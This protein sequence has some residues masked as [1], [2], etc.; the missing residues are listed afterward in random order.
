M[1]KQIT[2]IADLDQDVDDVIA[3][4]YLFNHHVLKEIITDPVPI[5]QI[6][7]ERRAHLESLGISVKTTLTGKHDYVFV[8]GAL[9]TV[10]SYI[11]LSYIDTL[12]MNGGFVGCNLIPKEHQLPKFKDKKTVRTF[13]FNCNVYAT[14]Q[15][16][17]SSE[18][19]IEN[20]ILVGKNVCHSYKNTDHDLWQAKEYTDLFK[21]YHAKPGKLQ[22]DM[23]M[24]HEGLA[25]LYPELN[26]TPFCDFKY[27]KPYNEGLIGNMTK[28]GSVTPNNKITP[29]RTV[30]AAVS[31]S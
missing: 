18:R 30:K 9:T 19:Q 2:Y 1:E 5:S 15:V 16:L 26:I 6:G 25:M 14:D 29:Y 3:A 22:H 7:K 12:V 23:L 24:C 27:V 4:H 8:G 20:I 10:A 28:W 21:Q 11:H 13:N 31:F 17:R